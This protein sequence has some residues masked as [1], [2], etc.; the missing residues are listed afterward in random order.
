MLTTIDYL[1]LTF[2]VSVLVLGTVALMIKLMIFALALDD[3]WELRDDPKTNPERMV[4]DDEAIASAGRVLSVGITV[5]I[6]LVWTLTVIDVVAVGWLRGTIAVGVLIQAVIA[7]I[8]GGRAMLHRRRLA[9][10]LNTRRPM[11]TPVRSSL[12]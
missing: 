6:G 5:A 8:Q 2:A 3:W 7:V 10:V 4:A 12:D 9:R 1:A 11:A